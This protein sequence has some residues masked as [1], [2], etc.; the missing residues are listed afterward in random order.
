MINLVARFPNDL[1]HRFK[2]VY[3][4]ELLI[5]LAVNYRERQGASFHDGHAINEVAGLSLF[6]C[7][8][9]LLDLLDFPIETLDIVCEELDIVLA[10]LESFELQVNELVETDLTILVRIHFQVNGI[11]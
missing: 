3:I 9:L 8:Q 7:G 4:E 2:L 10:V 6:Q 5:E 1:N 11:D